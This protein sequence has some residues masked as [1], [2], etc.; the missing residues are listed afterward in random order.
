MRFHRKDFNLPL[1]GGIEFVTI[2]VP[3]SASYRQRI[4]KER[5]NYLIEIIVAEA[6]LK[7]DDWQ[8]K[9]GGKPSTW[10]PPGRTRRA[11]YVRNLFDL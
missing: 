8:L 11:G 10:F 7:K 5:N 1:K 4:K 2:V 3:L 9:A 6:L